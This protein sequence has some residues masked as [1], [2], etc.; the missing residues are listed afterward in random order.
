MVTLY[1]FLFINILVVV[2]EGVELLKQAFYVETKV[3]F[4]PRQTVKLCREIV[5]VVELVFDIVNGVKNVTL[6]VKK[7][8][9][10]QLIYLNEKMYREGD[11]EKEKT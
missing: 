11:V 3:F 9:E 2:I 5:D 6:N 8:L 7:M 4:R 1:S 10:N